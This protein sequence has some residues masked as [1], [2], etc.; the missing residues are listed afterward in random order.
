MID[1]ITGRENGPENGPR[2]STPAHDS[3]SDCN[4][5]EGE[6]VDDEADPEPTLS[7]SGPELSLREPPPLRDRSIS[8]SGPSLK[9]G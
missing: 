6:Q 2:V 8:L 1:A 7:L 5:G 3:R 4:A 9:L